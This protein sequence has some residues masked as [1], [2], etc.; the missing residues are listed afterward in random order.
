MTALDRAIADIEAQCRPSGKRAFR[1]HILTAARAWRRE[2]DLPLIDRVEA[3]V[4]ALRPNSR[5]LVKVLAEHMRLTR[6][7]LARI[8]NN[9]AVQARMKRLRI[10]V[11]AEGLAARRIGNRRAA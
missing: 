10:A 2:H 7:E 8:P 1:S 11:A 4:Q 9:A 3:E 6:R 5:A